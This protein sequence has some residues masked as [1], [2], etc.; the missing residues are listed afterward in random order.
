MVLSKEEKNIYNKNYF[1][2]NKDKL[3]EQRK[4]YRE[5]NKEQI[6]SKV[7]EYAEKHKD[8]ILEYHKTEAYR[9]CVRISGWKQHGIISDNFDE[10]YNHYINCWKCEL[11]HVELIEGDTASNRRCLDHDHKTGLFR[12]ILC[13]T[14]NS[15]KTAERKPKKTKEEKKQQ[16]QEYRDNNKKNQ[17]IYGANRRFREKLQAFILS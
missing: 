12:N 7:K 8:K 2:K 14:C 9:K 3:K 1:E 10:L 15:W 13:N 16:L 4:I 17:K 5:K 6:A 11:C